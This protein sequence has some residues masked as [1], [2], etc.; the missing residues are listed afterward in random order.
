MMGWPA[1]GEED[2]DEEAT[3]EDDM[4]LDDPDTK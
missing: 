1:W 4:A 3:A 2:D